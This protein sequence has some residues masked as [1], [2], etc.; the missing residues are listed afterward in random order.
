M[1]LLIQFEILAS[2]L[3]RKK[4]EE[5]SDNHFFQRTSIH[6]VDDF[7]TSQK[8]NFLVHSEILASSVTRKKQ[9]EV[10]DNHFFQLTFIHYVDDFITSQDAIVPNSKVINM[11]SPISTPR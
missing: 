9:E 6:Y 8:V 11:H 3:T 2:S 4:Q 5:V 7:I 1:N 10:S